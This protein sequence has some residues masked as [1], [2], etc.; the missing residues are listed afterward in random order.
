LEKILRV[1]GSRSLNKHQ[2]KEERRYNLRKG[3]RGGGK[4]YQA[5]LALEDHIGEGGREVVLF[6][7]GGRV[8]SSRALSLKQG[9]ETS[10]REK[11]GKTGRGRERLWS[12][13]YR[14][15]KE[16]ALNGVVM[17]LKEP[18]GEGAERQRRHSPDRMKKGAHPKG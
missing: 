17:P 5:P 10:L 9:R 15:K 18:R 2:K 11:R 4:Y 7:T 12:E 8:R 13:N 1:G 16:K 14:Q 3:E 6:I